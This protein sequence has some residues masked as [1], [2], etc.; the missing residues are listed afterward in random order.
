MSLTQQK[1]SKQTKV[2][3]QT[4][5]HRSNSGFIALTWL[6]CEEWLLEFSRIHHRIILPFVFYDFFLIYIDIY[7][8][9]SNYFGCKNTVVYG[10][11]ISV[12][13]YTVLQ[14]YG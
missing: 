7:I 8:L 3:R 13:V 4:L 2:C 14:T 11:L 12:V 9:L 6:L 1:I 10:V 5:S